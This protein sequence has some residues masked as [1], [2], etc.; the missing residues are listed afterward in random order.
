MFELL[1][2]DDHEGEPGVGA[3]MQPAQQLERFEG[4]ELGFI[5]D[6]HPM[7]LG[8]INGELLAKVPQGCARSCV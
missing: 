6:D 4:D 1:G 7:L 8:E 3:V 2:P 5:D